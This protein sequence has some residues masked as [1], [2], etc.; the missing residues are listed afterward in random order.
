[1]SAKDNV[2]S[3]AILS[4]IENT[5]IFPPPEAAQSTIIKEYSVAG[6]VYDS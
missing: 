1:M 5:S 3:E 6:I 4:Y 2:P